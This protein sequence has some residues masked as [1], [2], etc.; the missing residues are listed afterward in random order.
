MSNLPTDGV[1]CEENSKCIHY[2]KN[3]NHR[4]RACLLS[5]VYS[6]KRGEFCKNAQFKE[7]EVPTK[8][9]IKKGK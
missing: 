5:D 1:I 7:A 4:D 6:V 2:T 3:F 8:I 9:D